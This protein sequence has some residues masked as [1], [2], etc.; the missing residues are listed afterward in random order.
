M[1]VGPSPVHCMLGKVL[2][3]FD[4]FAGLNEAQIAELKA[5][6]TSNMGANR[7]GK[8]RQGSSSALAVDVE[9]DE[10]H[11]ARTY[12]PSDADSTDTDW[13]KSLADSLA[14]IELEGSSRRYF[15]GPALDEMATEFGKLM[16]WARFMKE[17][18]FALLDLQSIGLVALKTDP[19]EAYVAL[20]QFHNWRCKAAGLDP[21]EKRDILYF[22]VKMQRKNSYDAIVNTVDIYRSNEIFRG[23]SMSPRGRRRSRSNRRSS[24]KRNLM[25]WLNECL[26]EYYP[27]TKGQKANPVY[28]LYNGVYGE[29]DPEGGR[30]G[31]E[32]WQGTVTMLG[33]VATGQKMSGKQC[34]KLSAAKAFLKGNLEAVPVDHTKVL[35]LDCEMVDVQGARRKRESCLARVAIVNYKGKVLLDTFCAP[36]AKVLDY[37]T[38]WSGVREENLVDAPHFKS[39]QMQVL[40]ILK[41]RVIVGHALHNDFRVLQVYKGKKDRRDTSHYT[42]F[43]KNGNRKMSLRELAKQELDWD[44]QWGEHSPITDAKASLEVYKKHCKQWEK[45]LALQ[46]KQEL[47][48]Q[49]EEFSDKWD[50]SRSSESEEVADDSDDSAK[51]DQDQST[52][53]AP[54]A[55]YDM[56]DFL[57]SKP[58]LSKG[59][60]EA[61]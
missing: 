21:E 42:P 11:L 55:S 59:K 60:G 53:K 44:I 9:R 23:K 37:K 19:L 30:E 28:R 58:F 7:R 47:V 22:Y 10:V 8:G 12:G 48:I 46:V 33:C 4:V 18:P 57:D 43:L 26:A 51:E 56:R 52:R 5:L 6:I 20:N 35:G 25:D 39:V 14:G 24:F 49:L 2:A 38:Q 50:E 54:G 16:W 61:G 41:G 31:A 29:N 3:C 27:G 17:F 36:K 45:Q 15:A 32:W 40:K 34:A 13:W 1:G